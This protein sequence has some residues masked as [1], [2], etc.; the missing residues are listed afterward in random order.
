MEMDI[1]DGAIPDADIDNM[2]LNNTIN[3][4]TV[5][6]DINDMVDPTAPNI[7]VIN[8]ITNV[9]VQRLQLP[10]TSPTGSNSSNN[11]VAVSAIDQPN[12]DILSICMH[13]HCLFII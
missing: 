6:I 5:A 2:T 9:D 3:I 11:G 13:Y 8:V 10:V 1:A 12:I 7:N 4:P